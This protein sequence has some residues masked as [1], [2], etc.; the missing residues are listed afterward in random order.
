MEEGGS[1]KS[2]SELE[3]ESCTRPKHVLELMLKVGLSN[4]LINGEQLS[5]PLGGRLPL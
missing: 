4:D 2:W 1:W 3:G 5:I